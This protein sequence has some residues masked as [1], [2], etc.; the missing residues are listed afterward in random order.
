MSDTYLKSDHF[1]GG[2]SLPVFPDPQSFAGNSNALYVPQG[3][4]PGG[5]L[6]DG[7]GLSFDLSDGLL[8][9]LFGCPSGCNGGGPYQ[10]ITVNNR[11]S[12]V[13]DYTQI[14]SFGTFTL[15]PAAVPGPTVGAGLPGLIAACGGLL[16]WWRRRQKTA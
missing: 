10:G 9:N 6:L 3:S 7:G 16:G 4:G 12:N 13:P 8:V 5:V 2:G 1:S 11:D 15:T 14:N